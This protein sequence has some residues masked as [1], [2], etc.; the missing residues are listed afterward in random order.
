MSQHPVKPI[1]S[2]KLALAVRQFRA[3][4][5]AD[6]PQSEP[7]AIVGI[8]CR[9][10]GGVRSPEEFW[11]LLHDGVDAIT[12]VPA[13]RWDADRYFDPDPQAPGKTNTRWGGF[14][15]HV[16][17]FDPLL[18]G[19]APREAASMD[20]QQRL[21]L[22][23][24]WEAFWDSGRAPESLAGSQ[25]GV[26]VAISGCDYARLLFEDAGTIGSHACAGA[27]HSIASGRV[28]YLLDL[29]GPSISVDTACSSSLVAIHLACQ[30]LRSGNCNLALAGGVNLYLLPEHFV[31]LAKL[32]MLS[33]DGRC[34]VF[35]AGA[36]GFVSG[37][38]CGLIVLKPL[39]D[40]LSHGDHIYA[41]IRGT[42][43]NQDGRT[44][45]LTAPNGL[46]QQQVIRAALQNARVL[47]SSIGYVETH[48]TGTALGDPIEVEALAETLGK[49]TTVQCPCALGAVK[50][51]IGHLEAAAGV[52]GLI[53]TALALEHEEIPPNLHYSELNPHISLQGT[54]FY[55]P[56]KP[57]A[58]RRNKEVRF[59]AV[60][61][62]G[63]GGTNAHA[64]LE[65]SPQFLRAE[66]GE[67]PP[68][69]YLLPISAR[70]GDAL[71][72]FARLYAEFF[73]NAVK[74]AAPY[75][76]CH[77]AAIRR[78]HY[79][80]RLAVV[81]SSR[82]EFSRLLGDFVSGHT[83]RG[84]EVGR[85]SRDGEAVVFVFSGQGSQW[86]GMGMSLYQRQPGF[87]AAMDE[88]EALIQLCAGWSVIEHLSAA[89]EVSQ[90][91]HTQFAQPAIFAVE[92]ALAKLW[93]SWGISPAMVIGHSA[94]EVAAAHIAGVL[95]LEEAV[96]VVV[97][98]GRLMEAASGK[99]K[100]A[101]VHRSPAAVAED[102]RKFGSQVSIAA[103]NSP[104][105]TTISGDSGAIAQLLEKW[106]RDGIG[107]CLVPVDYAFH[108]PQMDSFSL[109]LVRVLGSVATHAET[110]PIISTVYGKEA[111]G[112]DFG[113]A[114]WGK[115]IRHPVLFSNAVQAAAEKGFRTFL[116][117]GP[118]PV[119]LNSV[120]ECLGEAN[121]RF[122]PSLRR[123]Q[124]EMTSM[125]SSLGALY[126]AGGAVNW[127]AVY[128]AGAPPV[129]LPVYPYQRRSFWI[130]RRPKTEM[131]ET[132]KLH[133]LLG[134]PL[135]SPS[136]SGAAFQAELSPG[137]P[138]YL[139]DHRIQGSLLLPMTAF[140]EIAGAA[141]SK[142]VGK[143]KALVDVIVTNPLVLS[144]ECGLT[145]QALV[146]GDKFQVLSLRA[147]E[148]ILHASGRISEFSPHAT[149]DA[150]DQFT[151][152]SAIEPTS[153]YAGLAEKGYHFG[154]AFRTLESA[155][156]TGEKVLG[157]V[158]LQERERREASDYQIHPA[159]LDGCLQAVLAAV[160]EDG[161]GVYLPFAI[162]RLETYAPAG[163]DAWAR[164]RIHT[165]VG[166]EASP[167]SADI[168]VFNDR[169][170][171]VARLEGVRFKRRGDLSS[172]ANRKAYR[173]KWR[174][175]DRGTSA[176]GAS[177]LL[178]VAD[179]ADQGKRLAHELM[180]RG[181]GASLCSPGE[182]I[183][184]TG[185]FDA[186][187]RLIAWQ[188]GENPIAEQRRVCGATLSLAQELLERFPSSPPQLWFVTENAIAVTPSDNCDGLAQAPAWGLGR[189]IALE[190]PE[191]RCVRVDLDAA[192]AGLAWLAEEIVHPDGEEEIALREGQRFTSRLESAILAE[193]QPQRL[194]IPVRG[195]V[196]RLATEL[197]ERREPGSGEVEVEVEASA[198]NFRDVLNV[199]GMYPGDPGQPGL[200]FC[201]RIA[202]VGEGVE[203]YRPGDRVMG[204]AWNS[205]ASFVNTPALLVTRIPDALE[206]AE[207]A[208]LPNAFLTAMYCLIELGRLK[209]GDRI[210]IHAA[211]GGVGL[212]AVQLAQQAGAEI[213]ATAGSEI[214]RDYLRSLGISHVYSSR[215]LDFAREILRE[216]NGR[217]VNLV[218]NSLA[219]EFIDAG[220]AS[221]AEGGR[222][223]EIGKAGIWSADRVSALG[224]SIEYFPV[225][226]AEIIDSDP[227]KIQ[228]C[229]SQISAGV[230]QG[231]LRTL[232]LRA[233]EF[234]EARAGFRYMAQAK[235]IG[236]IV[237]RHP[238]PPRIFA[239]ATYLVTGGLGAIGLHVAQ[240]L[241]DRGAKNLVLVGRRGAS[242]A[243]LEQINAM[244][245]AGV[246]VEIRAADVCHEAEMKNLFGELKSGMPPLR[247]VIH[248]AGVVDDGVMSQ[249]NWK[250]FESVLAPKVSG[251]WN[252]HTLTAEATLD[253]FV[254]FSSVASLTGSPGQS[255][256]AA[257]NAFLDTLAHYRQSRGLPAL[258]VNWGPWAEAGM[259]ARVQAE[260]R[261]RVLAGLRA[262]VP[263]DC[264]DC[265]GL[266]LMQTAPQVSIADV[267][268]SKWDS[269]SRLVSEMIKHSIALPPSGKPDGI[270][271]IL[272]SS[273]AKDRRRVLISFLLEQL[274]R[275]IGLDDSY[276]I[277]ERQPLLKMG[278]DSLMAVEFRNFL[279]SALN[280]PLP[281][282]LLFDYPTLGAL[283]DYLNG[284]ANGRAETNDLGLADLAMLSDE[285][286]EQLL[287]EE[288]G[289]S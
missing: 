12:T 254:L 74:P 24:A 285:Q 229:L 289:Q 170:V 164:V 71:R 218:L 129:S 274:R 160:E 138:S 124:N 101:A 251:A 14:V 258:S 219:G 123:K 13:E 280:R 262:M 56:T 146:D 23:V 140:L 132:G 211:T 236:K 257:G 6:L 250:R 61:S 97:H 58:W 83:R 28:S 144:E 198:L 46:A 199:L 279:A 166:S 173:L 278:L 209:C 142:A 110:V 35:D 175:Q 204:I 154:P 217:G 34:K 249:Q 67:F 256:Y 134:R 233:F 176:P 247:G 202:R 188:T 75:S 288:L 171:L 72:D 113:V 15:P 118:H 162:A 2:A 64:V 156:R 185:K 52:A 131:R 157:R 177:R 270:L 191:F 126:V 17:M 244:R 94:G 115:N 111:K 284:S 226:L 44:S 11:R 10:P 51:N 216:T 22:E 81:A 30:S 39:A 269:P 221:L 182:R 1:S 225:D 200:E 29:R 252:L 268:W 135:K 260:G 8:G 107:C 165:N 109:E 43:V 161:E 248:C 45:V 62:F 70:T 88:C 197:M 19:I 127:P 136:L 91:H 87:R 243:A 167:M 20:P 246:R 137:D 36:N 104:E 168:D 152:P 238:A 116:E 47:P 98:R 122:V 93:Q 222:F 275:V 179:D 283:A 4:T 50:S 273:L 99:G 153:F 120:E 215:T 277:D 84:V 57:T 26:F 148:W 210:L 255:T 5:D 125:L 27:Y 114:Y 189:T 21:L 266:A 48:G 230:T 237:L 41:V 169:E 287:R 133:P 235:H 90:L 76:V 224:K 205:F 80:E 220:F 190:N 241:A 155:C 193:P 263:R 271:K 286:A 100:M 108:S 106:Q 79:E 281:A 159:L 187:V 37:E 86:P 253:F 31:G 259:A 180:T 117:V 105:S 242:T 151:G 181:C 7:I 25:T 213:F 145:I 139:A 130:E 119:L 239:D 195:S 63:F 265:F 69:P 89:E 9:F 33:P 92:V 261:K 158:R 163:A 66:A 60:S 276:F 78:S 201:G 272:E 112:A 82:D 85:V 206:P 103:S 59:A 49:E 264:L 95:T 223:I 240:Y 232:P 42:A 192:T 194:C 212:A 231:R 183:G 16:D 149:H 55:L 18:F 207:A 208:T 143:Q 73:E 38:G 196:D 178:I 172:V 65:E 186:V 128:P 141:V 121:A 53:K 234:S 102:L 150:I 77:S 267:D 96:R 282:T 227:R 3:Q 228:S 214:K 184:A 174:A 68:E 245:N 54:R 32:G 203:E 40:A 147:E